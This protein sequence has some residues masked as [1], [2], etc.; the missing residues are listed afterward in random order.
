MSNSR[1]SVGDR[2][3]RVNDGT[4]GV[5]TAVGPTDVAVRW[6]PSGVIQMVMPSML[7]PA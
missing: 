4:V 1:F 2:V 7:Q 6:E 3:I 5:V